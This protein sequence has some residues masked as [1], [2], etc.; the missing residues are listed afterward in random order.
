[1]K[2]ILRRYFIYINSNGSLLEGF[3]FNVKVLQSYLEDRCRGLLARVKKRWRYLVWCCLTRKDAQ[4]R[5][6]DE[7]VPPSSS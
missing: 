3:G 1:M 6:R 7:A 5:R 2:S 4:E